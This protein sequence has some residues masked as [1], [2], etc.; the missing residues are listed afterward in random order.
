MN[1]TCSAAQYLCTRQGLSVRKTYAKEE[2]QLVGVPLAR[3]AWRQGARRR[4]HLDLVLSQERG[5]L[6]GAQLNEASEFL[7]QES[8]WLRQLQSTWGERQEDGREQL[9][10][11]RV[12][13]EE[14]VPA[15][16]L[17]V[18]SESGEVCSAFRQ[19][20]MLTSCRADTLPG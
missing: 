4:G 19:R 16:G 3:A 11:R 1:G 17:A 18:R 5:E 10:P 6:H 7:G 15:A 13:F 12:A 2:H 20:R 8:W 14:C 9:V